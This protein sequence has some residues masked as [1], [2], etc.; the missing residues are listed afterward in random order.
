MIFV[1]PLAPLALDLGSDYP[2]VRLQAVQQLI[3]RLST[4]GFLDTLRQHRLTALIYH[5]LSQFS[6]ETVGE[7]PFLEELR[8]E[9]FGGLRLCKIQERETRFLVELLAEVGIEVIL[10][11]GADIRHR[12]YEDP[13]CRPMSDLDLLISPFDL[14]KAH[15]TLERRGYTLIPWNL[16]LRPGFTAQF[17]WVIS[18]NSPTE[19]LVEVHWE[20]QEVG[21]FYRL[22][23]GPLRK[24]ALAQNLGNL[25]VLILSAEHLMLHLILHTF[26]E[27]ECA[28][29]LKLIDLERALQRL[30]LD[31]DFFL[32]EV[33]RYR[34]QGPVIL[35]F[36]ELARFRPGLVPSYVWKNLTTNPPGWA[37]GYLLRRQRGCMLVAFVMALR[38]HLPLRAWPAYLRAKLWPTRSYLEANNRLF[39]TRIDYLSHLLGLVKKLDGNPFDFMEM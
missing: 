27:I 13:V 10:L 24:Q 12:L 14:E 30:S 3:R 36:R 6:R 5:T 28:P 35:M 23:Y 19:N 22:P 33:D 38:R 25:P 26:D 8:R 31:W 15:T 21:T 1:N 2:G 4:P 17:R 32:E 20:I 37:E 16:D 11:K 9:Y 34:I 39:P 29:L 7:V 18:Y